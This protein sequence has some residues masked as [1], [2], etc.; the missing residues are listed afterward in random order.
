MFN[1]FQ[2]S[3]II[4]RS[5]KRS[6]YLPPEKRIINNSINE[7]SKINKVVD[8]VASTSDYTKELKKATQ[9]MMEMNAHYDKQTTSLQKH[10]Q[11]E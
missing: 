7:I 3:E 8:V 10:P 4:P 6:K 11:T 2:L 1:S 9:K 5:G